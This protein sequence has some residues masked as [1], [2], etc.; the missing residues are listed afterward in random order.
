MSNGFRVELISY[1]GVEAG[2]YDNMLFVAEQLR[3]SDDQVR[4]CVFSDID[5]AAQYS[6]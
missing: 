5:S 1:E 2:H 3:Y 4:H 6:L